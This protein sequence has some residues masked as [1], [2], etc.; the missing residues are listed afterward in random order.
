MANGNTYDTIV[1]GV[2]DCGLELA[3]AG[4][5]RVAVPGTQV[6]SPA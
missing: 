1:K 3:M 2:Y 5:Y 6:V 4:Q